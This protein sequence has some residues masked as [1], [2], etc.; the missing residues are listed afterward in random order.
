MQRLP[1]HA[2]ETEDTGPALPTPDADG[3]Y[4]TFQRK[5]LCPHFPL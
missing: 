3:N 1:A 4:K 2:G 5:V